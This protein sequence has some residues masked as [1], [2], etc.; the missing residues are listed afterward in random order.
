MSY[1]P[2]WSQGFRALNLASYSDAYLG[3][4]PDGKQGTYETLRLMANLVRQWKKSP[5]VRN[6][7]TALC[8]GVPHKDS[9]GEIHAL[10]VYVRDAIRYVGDVSDLETIS[11]PDITIDTAAGD[12]DDKALLLASLLESIGYKT[13]FVAMGWNDGSGE[14][15][16]VVS[17]VK[18]GVR[19]LNLETTEGDAIEPGWYPDPA[20]DNALEV[21][22]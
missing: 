9:F 10:F 19:W 18:F 16:H 12:C 1:A 21:Y 3:S 4:I 6:K 17:Q 11:T 2:A 8:A 22:C 14:F 20:P 15:S 13:R 7:A 5:D